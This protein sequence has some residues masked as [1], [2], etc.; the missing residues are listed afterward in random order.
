VAADT[1]G[2]RVLEIGARVPGLAVNGDMLRDGLVLANLHVGDIEG[3][4]RAFNVL[5]THGTR[6]RNDLRT[7]LLDAWIHRAESASAAVPSAP[8]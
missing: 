4:R 6:S 7:R 8:R 2:D 3:A 5:L 1:V